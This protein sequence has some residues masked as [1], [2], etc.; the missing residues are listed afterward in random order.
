MTLDELLKEYPSGERIWSVSLSTMGWTL[1]NNDG[2]HVLSL[3]FWGPREYS[4]IV[5]AY[6]CE[7]SFEVAIEKA[8]QW[9]QDFVR[10]VRQASNELESSLGPP[11]GSFRETCWG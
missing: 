10:L 1:I 6:F 7:L 11:E 5:H 4:T 8:W 2:H 3:S 9:V